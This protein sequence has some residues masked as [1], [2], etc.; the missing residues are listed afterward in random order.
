MGATDFLVRFSAEENENCNK[1]KL[2]QL[3]VVRIEKYFF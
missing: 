1:N 2:K 3:K